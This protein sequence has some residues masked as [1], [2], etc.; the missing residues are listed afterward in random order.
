MKLTNMKVL[1]LLA[2]IATGSPVRTELI[3]PGL[4]HRSTVEEFNKMLDC[5]SQLLSINRHIQT[6]GTKAKWFKNP[7]QAMFQKRDCS[8]AT[9]DMA[10]CTLVCELQENDWC[11][12]DPFIGEDVCGSGLYCSESRICEPIYDEYDFDSNSSDFLDNL[13]ETLYDQPKAHSRRK[14]I[15]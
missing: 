9:Y 5:Q 7:H 2:S 13:F 10:F 15:Q 14:H 4:E 1:L 6:H 11:E 3:E 12:P 8:I